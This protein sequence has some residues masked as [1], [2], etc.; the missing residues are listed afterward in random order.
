MERLILNT[1]SKEELEHLI[2]CCVKS[3]LEKHFQPPPNT[4]TEFIS[5]KKAARLLGI[6]LVTLGEYCKRGMIPSYRIGNRVL[7][8]EKEIVESVSKIKT[9][10]SQREGLHENK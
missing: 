1:F 4:K 5:R 10:N 9:V 3:E 7:L 2:K 8:I 6:S